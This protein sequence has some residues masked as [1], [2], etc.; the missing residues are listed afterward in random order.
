MSS[1]INPL[2]MP[3]LERPDWPRHPEGEYP[4]LVA[5]QFDNSGRNALQHAVYLSK[6]HGRAPLHVATVVADENPSGRASVIERHTAALDLAMSE[7]RAFAQECAGDDMKN[8]RF[9]VRMGETVETIFQLALDYDVE[10]IVVG[11]H[12]RKGLAKLRIGSVAQRL[13]ENARCPVLIAVPR[14]YAG[15]SPTLIPDPPR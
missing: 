13:V 10:L 12:A 8:M 1:S 9:H 7:L 15:M 4:I 5:V 14:D 3:A 2:E 6:T 11:T